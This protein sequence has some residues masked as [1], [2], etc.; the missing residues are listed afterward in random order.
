MGVRKPIRPTREVQAA[1]D[2]LAR[3]YKHTAT[4]LNAIEDD[5]EAFEQATL[6]ADRLHALADAASELRAKMVGRI[7][8]REE[9]SLAQL[10]T[11][12]G[13]SK[14]RADQMVKRAN[15]AGREGGRS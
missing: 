3:A 11:R 13:V 2:A 14:T 5:Q 8:Q 9:L 1:I 10:A 15:E 4:V 6:V 7:W 12:I